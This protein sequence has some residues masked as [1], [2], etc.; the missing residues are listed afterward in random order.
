MQTCSGLALNRVAP[1]KDNEAAMVMIWLNA[2]ING[3]SKMATM[4][5]LPGA[6]W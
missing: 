3:I 6:R 1:I 4:T 2:M 5:R